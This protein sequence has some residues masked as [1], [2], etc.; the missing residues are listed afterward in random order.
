MSPDAAHQPITFSDE[1]PKAEFAF[2]RLSP[3]VQRWADAG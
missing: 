1:P 2:V 3:H